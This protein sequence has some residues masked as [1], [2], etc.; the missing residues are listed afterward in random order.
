MRTSWSALRRSP[1]QRL[2]PDVAL[3]QLFLGLGAAAES[4]QPLRQQQVDDDRDVQDEGEDLERR[5][6]VRQLVELERQQQD[7]RDER[8]V[9]RPA[10]LEPESYGLGAFEQRVRADP[11]R[12][13][14]HL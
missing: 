13:Q 11:E 4:E 10:L 3:A 9:L 2:D 12:R 6:A 5:D 7:G 14:L 1:Q 8:Q